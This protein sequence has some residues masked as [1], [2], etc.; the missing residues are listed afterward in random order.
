M[1]T[2]NF[3]WRK[4]REE[5]ATEQ[6]GLTVLG[7]VDD[8]HLSDSVFNVAGKFRDPKLFLALLLMMVGCF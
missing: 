1:I 4:G 5:W 7:E 6:D 8:S 2:T 3:S